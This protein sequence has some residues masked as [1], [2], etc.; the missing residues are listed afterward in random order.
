MQGNLGSPAPD[1]PL[2]KV[3]ALGAEGGVLTVAGVEPRL[4]GEL[5]EH[6]GLQ[7]VHQ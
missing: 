2:G 5:A 7:V 3:G 4:V 1:A 6:P